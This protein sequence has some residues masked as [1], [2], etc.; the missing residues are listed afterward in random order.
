MRPAKDPYG[1]VGS[2]RPPPLAELLGKSVIGLRYGAGRRRSATVHRRLLRRSYVG[3]RRWNC[4]YECRGDD[5]GRRRLLIS[6]PDADMNRPAITTIPKRCQPV[7]HDAIESGAAAS[8]GGAAGL[9]ALSAR[10]RSL[11]MG[12]LVDV[13]PNH[14]GVATPAYIWR[15]APGT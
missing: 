7:C 9:T 1:A 5:T 2:A 4:V 12:V 6:G 13:V 11:G 3:R 10:A 15:S 14:V 8:R